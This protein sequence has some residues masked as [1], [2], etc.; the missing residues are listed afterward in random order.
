MRCRFLVDRVKVAIDL[1]GEPYTKE[2]LESEQ[3]MPVRFVGKEEIEKKARCLIHE[4]AGEAVREN[5]GKLR[6]KAREV[7][8]PGGSSRKNFEAYVRLLHDSRLASRPC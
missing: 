5:V 1:K 3:A 4:A 6:A 7:G 2:D 8:A